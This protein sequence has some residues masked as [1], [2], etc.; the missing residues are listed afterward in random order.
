MWLSLLIQDNNINNTDTIQLKETASMYGTNKECNVTN[1]AEPRIRCNKRSMQRLG[2]PMPVVSELAKGLFC[3]F[4]CTI[5]LSLGGYRHRWNRSREIYKE[6]ASG[7]GALYG[8][9]ACERQ[10]GLGVDLS[11]AG[12][13]RHWLES[14][15]GRHHEGELHQQHRLQLLNGGHHVSNASTLSTD[16]PSPPT[17]IFSLPAPYHIR[18]LFGWWWF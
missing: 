2:S 17:I 14:D 8:Q 5:S 6:A 16:S 3:F 9:P 7:G 18:I 11:T 4:P 15:P 13:E 10:G 12:R 1:P